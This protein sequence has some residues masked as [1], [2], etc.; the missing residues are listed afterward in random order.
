M[1]K[2]FC[3]GASDQICLRTEKSIEPEMEPSYFT[4]DADL[5]TTTVENL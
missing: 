2:G 5:Q 3:S 4:E 1:Q